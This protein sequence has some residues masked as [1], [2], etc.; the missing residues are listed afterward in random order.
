MAGILRL[1]AAVPLGDLSGI[2]RPQGERR[3]PAR[4][5]KITPAATCVLEAHVPFMGE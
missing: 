3:T 4:V 2:G 1:I 5:A